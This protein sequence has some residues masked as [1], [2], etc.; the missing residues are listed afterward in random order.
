MNLD[1]AGARRRYCN[2]TLRRS[3]IYT[4]GDRPPAPKQNRERHAVP[5]ESSYRGGGPAERAP[6]GQMWAASGHCC[7]LGS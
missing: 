1:L 5:L 2:E 6:A 3:L 7:R 4:P